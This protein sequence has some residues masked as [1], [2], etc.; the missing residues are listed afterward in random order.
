[1]CMYVS[2][3][4]CVCVCSYSDR[5]EE[6]IWLPGAGVTGTRG[7]FDMGTSELGTKCPSSERVAGAFND[8]AIFPGPCILF[9]FSWELY[10]TNLTKT[11]RSEVDSPAQ[12]NTTD[13]R[14]LEPLHA[15][16]I[17]HL[18]V[19]VRPLTRQSSCFEAR[20]YH[21]IVQMLKFMLLN[22]LVSTH[23]LSKNIIYAEHRKHYSN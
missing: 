5:P 15:L 20:I 22:Q 4:T 11:G 6:G 17:W 18:S 7:P 1:M 8:W 23:K 21:I 3:A 19:G 10:Y 9:F 14:K 2:V 13:D 16:P 12:V